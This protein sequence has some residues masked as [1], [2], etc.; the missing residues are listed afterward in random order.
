MTNAE[1]ANYS[2]KEAVRLL[3]EKSME[4]TLVERYFLLEDALEEIQGLPQTLQQGK[5]LSYVLN[6]ASLPIEPYDLLL[7][8]FDDH[9]PTQEEQ[10]RLDRMFTTGPRPDDNPIVRFNGGHVTIDSET[11]IRIGVTGYINK[12]SQRMEEV[13]ATNPREDVLNYLEGIRITFEA[14]R[15]YIERYGKAAEEAGLQ[16]CARVCF[17]LVQG[18]PK[19]FREA[20]QLVLFVYNIY[21]IYAGATVACLNVGR[22]DVWLLPLYLKDL[23]SGTLTEEL[24]GCLIDDFSARMSLHL[25]RGEH[26]MAYLSP[27]YAQTGWM[28]NHVYESPGYITIGGYS[29]DVDQRENPLSLLFAEH[30]HAGLKNPTYICRYYRG[31]NHR[32]WDILSR[33]VTENASL[34]LY[35]DDT[36]IPAHRHIGVEQRD[37]VNYSIHPCNWAD[38]A[39]GSEIVGVCGMQLPFVLDAVLHSGR[40]FQSMDDVYAAAA[41]AYTD[42]IRATFA[43][44]RKRYRGNNESCYDTLSLTECFREDCIEN[45]GKKERDRVKYPALYV[46]LR[47]IGTAAD[48]LAAVDWLVFGQ[49][50]YSLEELVSTADADF[51]N[52]PDVLA[53]CKKAPKFGR[54]DDFADGHAVR[55]M[56]T[57][58]D[59]IDKEAT[60]EDGVRDVLTLNITINDS[61]HLADGKGMNATVDGRRKG[62]PFTENLSP[63]VGASKSITD[64]L[65][66]VAKLPFE[67]I[68]SGALNVRLSGSILGGDSGEK[69]I[70]ALIKS[71]FEQGGMQLQFNIV[72]TDVLRKAQEDPDAYRDLLVR[73]TGY[74]AVFVDMCEGAQEEFIRREELK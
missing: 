5:G 4:S 33:K 13:K 30:I 26:Q 32:L 44:Y 31:G 39:G 53:A 1:K 71:Y 25:G 19:T 56:S 36:V 22:L 55:L 40:T 60:N 59:A 37:A 29:S 35:N 67:R 65:N 34:L 74:S 20:L 11:L 72:D 28:R 24:A 18:A 63:A 57:L 58:L 46:A 42:T 16:E 61:N 45:A 52:R 66:S 27:A 12:A 15:D 69:T 43:D 64:V 73:I 49:K 70:N 62:E 50:K 21:L 54:N 14:I 68:H 23:E 6:R 38:I 17:S 7:G 9:V 2:V 3:R 8:R 48:M 51:A 41:E 10:D 47:N